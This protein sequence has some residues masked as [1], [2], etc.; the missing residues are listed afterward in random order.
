V[1]ARLTAYVVAFIVGVTVIAGLI[2]GA[3]REDDGAVDLIVINGHVYPADGTDDLAEAV[4]VRGNKIVRIGSNR[5]IQRLSRAQTIV[6]DAEGGAVLPGFNDAH[7]HLLNGGLSL[8][9]VDLSEATSLEALKETVRAWAQS[10][11]DRE[12]ITGRGWYYQTF[13]TGLPTRQLLDALVPDR[14]A[15]LIAYDGHTGWANSRALAAAGIS[16]RTINPKN[17]VIVRDPHN[18]Q[19]SG[20][21]K[22]AAM[23]LMSRVTPQPTSEDK[24]AAIRGAL[25]EAH[26]F[27]VTSMQNAGGSPDDLLLYDQLRKQGDLTVRV[28]QALTADATLTEADLDRLEAVRK[29]FADD[30]LLKTGGIKLILD[31]VIESH[32]AAMLEPYANRPSVKGDPRFT[33]E[34]LNHIVT[35]LDRRGW[36]VQTHAIGDRAVRMTLD[37]YEAAAAANG[38]PS[39]GRRHRVEH[40]E[41]IDPVDIPRF[42]KLGVVASIQPY[43]GLPSASPPDVWA[44]NIGPER[45][46]R[47]WISGS[48]SKAGGPLAFGSDW[49]VV[50]LDPM[51]G[52][53]VAV[54]R[55]TLA[56]LP[57]GGWNP[58]ER[59]PLRRAIDAYTRTAAWASFDEQRKGTLNR[60]MLADLVVLS[61]NIFD[62]PP[63]RLT[64]ATVDVTIFDGKVVYRR[65]SPRT[66]TAH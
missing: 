17:G 1:A 4:A 63:S 65:T 43:H 15:Y 64:D 32:T 24:L 7:A 56:G 51:K 21:L 16:S 5:E 60:D 22:E 10:H 11:P 48:I 46:A 50:T 45:A 52:L 3:Q 62:L 39:K 9:Q 59:L 38:A 37:A 14:P 12:W 6:I 61:A 58:A 27:G 36:Q 44:T 66:T 30:P 40:I 18:A 47:G 8:D 33:V 29:Q 23:A 13:A 28:Y 53:H 19:P 25:E 20:T 55:T 41:T 42:G 2:V 31:G 57:E 35:L 26:R 54:N 49:P 34:Q